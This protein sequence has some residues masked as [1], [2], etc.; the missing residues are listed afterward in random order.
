MVV[1]DGPEQTVQPGEML[2][3]GNQAHHIRELVLLIFFLVVKFVAE[4]A[5]AVAAV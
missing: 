4:E 5:E 3:I 1:L 2:Y